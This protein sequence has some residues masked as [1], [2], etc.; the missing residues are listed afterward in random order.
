MRFLICTDVA[1]RGIDVR[2]LP[3]GRRDRKI[4]DSLLD[5]HHLVI[6][7]TLPDDKESYIH[8]IGRVGRAERYLAR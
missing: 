6:N 4:E 7:M 8:R 3:F 2:G 5:R 1:A